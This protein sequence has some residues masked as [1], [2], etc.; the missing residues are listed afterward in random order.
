MCLKQAHC[1]PGAGNAIAKADSH[2]HRVVWETGTDANAVDSRRKVR[3]AT[4]NN[5]HN[6]SRSSLRPDAISHTSKPSRPWMRCS[7]MIPDIS[8]LCSEQERS[9]HSA[10]RCPPH[11]LLDRRRLQRRHLYWNLK[12]KKSSFPA[13]AHVASIV[14]NIAVRP[15]EPH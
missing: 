4:T 15:A 9:T 8:Q 5:K 10:A 14:S 12:S 2:V 13:T 6:R 11:P 1:P 3:K 7:L